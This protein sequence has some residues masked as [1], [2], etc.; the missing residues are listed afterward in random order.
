MICRRNL[1]AAGAGLSLTGLAVASRGDAQTVAA[2]IAPIAK[3]QVGYQD[4]PRDGQVCAQCVYFI[5]KPALA[6]EPES[7]CEMVAG[8]INPAGWCQI[9][10]PK[11]G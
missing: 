4:V 1:L 3:E 9:W 2:P 6:G 10:A 8:T 7:R 11:A 5:F